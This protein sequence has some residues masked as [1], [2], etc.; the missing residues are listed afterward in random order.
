[1]G[2]I[3]KQLLPALTAALLGL[4]A[5]V[6]G[7]T[8]HYAEGLSYLSADPSACVN[9]HIMR[10]QFDAWQKA[11]HHSTATCA[12]C[13]L[14]AAFPDKYIAKA[15]NGWSHSRAFTLQDF[16]EPI[17][18]TPKNAD[19]LHD[20]CLRCHG[21]LIDAQSMSF[22]GAAPRCVRCHAAVGH[23]E[24]VGLGGS[25]LSKLEEL[26]TKGKNP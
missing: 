25:M 21:A 13:H 15:E 2:K 1:M 12:D 22:T 5:G 7:I 26:E 3:K 6:G 4:S 8:F 14:P 11:S 24:P 23:G 17:F 19:V 10:P 20:N 16:A 18:I 9:C